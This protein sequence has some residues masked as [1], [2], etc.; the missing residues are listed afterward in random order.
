MKEASNEPPDHLS[1]ILS[2]AQ[3]HVYSQRQ[4]GGI[5]TSPAKGNPKHIDMSIGKAA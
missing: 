3:E 1:N 4:F 2:K 5:P